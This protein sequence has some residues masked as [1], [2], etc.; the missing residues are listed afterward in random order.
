MKIAIEAPI[1][2]YTLTIFQLPWFLPS[3]EESLAV[4]KATPTA[5]AAKSPIQLLTIFTYNLRAWE[6]QGRGW[7]EGDE[8]IHLLPV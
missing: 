8:T 5:S 1:S 7:A 3:Q 4:N 6:E 2:L